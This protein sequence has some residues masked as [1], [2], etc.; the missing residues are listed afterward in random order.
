MERGGGAVPG[1][2][3]DMSFGRDPPFAPGRPLD[4]LATERNPDAFP[5][6]ALAPAGDGV[7]T[8][9]TPAAASATE[10]ERNPDALPLANGVAVAPAGGGDAQQP[11]TT[12]TRAPGQPRPGAFREPS[13]GLHICLRLHAVTGFGHHGDALHRTRERTRSK[14]KTGQM[15]CVYVC[16]CVGGRAANKSSFVLGAMRRVQGQNFSSRCVDSQ[17][18]CRAEK[19]NA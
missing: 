2:S 11:K 13:L 18:P 9:V 17:R 8:T 15:Q 14:K 6:L 4:A 19:C 3:T 16:V 12:P 1:G 5:T 7:I 10:T